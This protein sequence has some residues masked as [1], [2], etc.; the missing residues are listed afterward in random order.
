[1]NSN[2]KPELKYNEQQ[3]IV[4]E[5]RNRVIIMNR[6]LIFTVISVALIFMSNE[7]W[8]SVLLVFVIGYILS[9]I[10]SIRASNRVKNIIGISHAEQAE[11]WSKLKA[12]Y[13]SLSE[14]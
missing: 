2:K 11:I 13:K 4:A 12:D 5:S 8:F 3:T 1:M 9:V 7:D 14:N 10:N 6:I